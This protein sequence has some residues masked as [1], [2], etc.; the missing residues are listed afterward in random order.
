MYR[1]SFAVDAG[2]LAGRLAEQGVPVDDDGNATITPEIEPAALQVLREA[3]E[4]GWM[5]ELLDDDDVPGAGDLIVVRKVADGQIGG[6][7]VDHETVYPT[8]RYLRLDLAK[9]DRIHVY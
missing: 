1:M 6:D 5:V 8:G 2:Y 9:V 4:G 7:V 3:A